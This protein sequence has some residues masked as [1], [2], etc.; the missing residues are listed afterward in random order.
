MN[1]RKG[2]AKTRLGWI[3]TE[4][5]ISPV[6]VVESSSGCDQTIFEHTDVIEARLG[7]LNDAAITEIVPARDRIVEVHPGDGNGSQKVTVEFHYKT[8][9]WTEDVYV[10]TH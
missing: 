1:E 2:D 6:T 9:V 4:K 7:K 3:K 8:G 10:A 5:G